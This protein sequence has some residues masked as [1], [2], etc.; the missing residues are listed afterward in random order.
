MKS[1]IRKRI[2]EKVYLLK[3][4]KQQE[5]F[6]KE[7]LSGIDWLILIK[8][9]KKNVDVETERS[10]KIHEKKLTSLTKNIT[11]PFMPD[12]IITNLSSHT[13]SPDE[14]DLLQQG[15]Q[16]CIPPRYLNKTD[17]FCTFELI[18]RFLKEDLKNTEDTGHLKA[19]H[20]ILLTLI[21]IIITQQKKL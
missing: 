12:E 17:V 7:A 4:R 16:H 18:H 14:L 21:I 20:P 2:K 11:N 8:A 9:I 13:L 10:I 3:D 1:A 19:E 5:S 15:L 6:I